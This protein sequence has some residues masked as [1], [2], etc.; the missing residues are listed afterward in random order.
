MLGSETAQLM[1]SAY[2]RVFLYS[3]VD[4]RPEENTSLERCAGHASCAGSGTAT[5]SYTKQP[6]MAMCLHASFLFHSEEDTL[7][8]CKFLAFKSFL[9]FLVLQGR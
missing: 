4:A 2:V 8:Y 6:G 7:L 3:Q 5:L 9:I 1:S